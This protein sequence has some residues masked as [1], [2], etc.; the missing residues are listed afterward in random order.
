M[1]SGSPKPGVTGQD[2]PC[3]PY[4]LSPHRSFMV[5]EAILKGQFGTEIRGTSPMR[6]GYGTGYEGL[7]RLG[8]QPPAGPFPEAWVSRK[9]R[10]RPTSK[11]R[12]L[13]SMHRHRLN[14]RCHC[15]APIVL[16]S[17]LFTVHSSLPLRADIVLRRVAYLLSSRLRSSHRRTLGNSFSKG[18]AVRAP[19]DS[20]R[21]FPPAS[22]R[23]MF[24]RGRIEKKGIVAE[25][26]FA[27]GR[28]QDTP[29][30]KAS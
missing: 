26:V 6:P 22:F 7:L 23:Q 11:Q 4:G 25:A 29:S 14:H 28:I 2:R 13:C 17:S 3:S 12:E 20:P 30:Q 18:S 24:F 1:A 10:A 27:P 9:D 16:F 5:P 21:V 8:E 15:L 19:G